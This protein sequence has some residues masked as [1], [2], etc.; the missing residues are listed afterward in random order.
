MKKQKSIDW[1]IIVTGLFCLTIIEAFALCNGIDG[2]I[3]TMVV[4]VIAL[5][6]GIAIP[7]NII[8]G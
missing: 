4:G 5:T 3:L 7:Q 2:K 8:K 1:R 6:I